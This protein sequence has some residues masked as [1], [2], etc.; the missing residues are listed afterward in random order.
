MT[1]V[2][3]Q[4]P[5]K[6]TSQRI[7]SKKVKTKINWKNIFKIISFFTVVLVFTVANVY[8]N[9]WGRSVTELDHQISKLELK[10]ENEKILNQELTNKARLQSEASGK[11]NM[12]YSADSNVV[13]SEFK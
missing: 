13:V 9:R 3:V 4:I 11:I 6:S 8:N 12:H 10:L 5:A 7:A 1:N 2:K